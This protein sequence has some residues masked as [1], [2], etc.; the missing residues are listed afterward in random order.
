MPTSAHVRAGDHILAHMDVAPLSRW[1]QGKA[2]EAPDKAEAAVKRATAWWLRTA[3][4]R[5]PVRMSGTKSQVKK[6]RKLG[7]RLP[8]FSKVGRG[9]LRKSTRAYSLRS[10][11]EIVGGL[12]NDAPY[13]IWLAA[14]TRKIAGGEVMRWRP[15]DPLVTMWDAKR[16]ARS[17]GIESGNTA[18]PILRP[19]HGEAW[20]TLAKELREKVL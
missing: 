4:P 3:Q 1:L 2:R 7:I 12:I 6:A 19:W 9:F 11:G 13:A 16:N 14:G 10:G 17:A 5:I 8:A 18:M 20:N 15:G